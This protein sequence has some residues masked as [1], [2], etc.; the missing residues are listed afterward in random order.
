ILVS[1]QMLCLI[2][3]IGEKFIWY[4][5]LMIEISLF[6]FQ[7]FRFII[8]N[9]VETNGI[10]IGKLIAV[11]IFSPIMLVADEQTISSFFIVDKTER[12]RSDAMMC[13]VFS[14]FFHRFVRIDK[15]IADHAIIDEWRK[16]LDKRY[17]EG[18]IIRRLQSG[19]AAGKFCFAVEIFFRSFNDLKIRQCKGISRRIEG[20]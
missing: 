19:D 9:E 10:E 1:F 12:P 8:L 7:Q 2:Y 15:G 13:E 20:T 17:N 16:G 11:I 18:R 6:E 5:I 3:N 14:I 4:T